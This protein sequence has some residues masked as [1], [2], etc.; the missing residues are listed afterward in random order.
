V[1]FFSAYPTYS[2]KQATFS[3][4]NLQV[5]SDNTYVLTVTGSDWSGSLSFPDQGDYQATPRGTSQTSYYGTYTVTKADNLSTFVLSVP[6][7]IVANVQSNTQGAVGY[8][9]D[10]AAWTDDMSTASS[11][12]D[13]AGY[14]SNYAFA[15]PLTIIVDT[16][17]ASFDWTD[18]VTPAS[19]AAAASQSS[20]Q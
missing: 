5:F 6:T 15:S 7:R 8:F 2:Y 11:Q 18:I 1:N 16:S 20:I 10:T 19:K 9:I 12:D 3:M 4:E 14:M 17:L 13:S